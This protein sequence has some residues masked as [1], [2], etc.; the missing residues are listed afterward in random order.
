MDGAGMLDAKILD[1]QLK[2]HKLSAV[3]KK[4]MAAALNSICISAKKADEKSISI[5]ASKILAQFDLTEVAK[6]D[7]EGLLPKEGRLLFFCDSTDTTFGFDPAD[8]G[9]WRVHFISDPKAKLRRVSPPK[10]FDEW[11][12]Y[13]ACKLTFRKELTIPP[14]MS[15]AES[16]L[17]LTEGQRNHYID[18]G[19]ELG[20]ERQT[21]GGRLHQLLGHPFQIQTDMAVMSA[22]ASNG[23]DM[24]RMDSF[25]QPG[26]RELIK[27]AEDWRLL[28]Q[29]DS[30][31][32]PKMQW[33]DNGMLYFWLKKDD[34]KNRAFDKCWFCLQCS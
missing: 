4:I 1:A 12:T 24:G 30:D 3:A 5:G 31:S 32:E 19:S 15:F 9:G 21:K 2:K 25:E 16:Q 23:I 26:A 29:L 20:T 34:L 17:E 18:L 22:L 13:T 14:G 11:H 27:D 33:S 8:S 28:F 10:A 6:F 7:T